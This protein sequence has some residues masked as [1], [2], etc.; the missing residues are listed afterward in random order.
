MQEIQEM[1]FRS[2]DQENLLEEEMATHFSI[3]VW[4]IAW[5]EEFAGL[6]SIGLQELDMTEAT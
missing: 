1:Q 6:P 2:L 4:E 3:L 5:T